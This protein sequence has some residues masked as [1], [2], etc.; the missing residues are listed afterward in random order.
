MSLKHF[1]QDESKWDYISSTLFKSH[2]GVVPLQKFD[3]ITMESK[4]CPTN[5]NKKNPR[6]IRAFLFQKT[7]PSRITFSKMICKKKMPH[8]KFIPSIQKRC[9]R[10]IGH[11]HPSSFQFVP[12]TQALPRL[13][14]GRSQRTPAADLTTKG[15]QKLHLLVRGNT[16]VG[17]YQGF[18]R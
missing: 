13:R 3:K 8:R 9:R 10:I 4:S 7:N 12:R 1:Q 11:F 16:S 5:L 18:G 6:E 2:S 17:R 15:I 14:L